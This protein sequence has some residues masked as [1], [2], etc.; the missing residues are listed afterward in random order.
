[1][2]IYPLLFNCLGKTETSVQVCPQSLFEL[3]TAV[4]QLSPTYPPQGANVSLAK[5]NFSDRLL[6]NG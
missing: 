6:L 4:Q 2:M 1:M 3:S 5:D